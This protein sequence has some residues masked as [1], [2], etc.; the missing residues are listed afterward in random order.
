MDNHL[1]KMSTKND[2][3][4]AQDSNVS[5]MEGVKFQKLKVEGQLEGDDSG[6]VMVDI[7]RSGKDTSGSG[8]N[9]TPKVSYYDEKKEPL[10]DDH[11]E[12]SA[13]FNTS[14]TAA[15]M[16]N[17]DVLEGGSNNIRDR[18]GTQFVPR[19]PPKKGCCCTVF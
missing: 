10:L 8:Q 2:E 16:Y 4:K 1:K 15:A 17:N 3:M 11:S 12:V 19:E 13:S 14:M 9:G 18:Q 7:T 6:M 5:S